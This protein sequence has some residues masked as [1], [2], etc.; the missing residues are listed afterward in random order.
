[1]PRVS[2]TGA[3][4]ISLTLC[5][6]S[7]LTAAAYAGTPF[8]PA[9]RG[10]GEP[11][12]SRGRPGRIEAP[13]PPTF[14]PAETPP[15]PPQASKQGVTAKLDVKLDRGTLHLHYTG[16][17]VQGMADALARTF[18]TN[19][20]QSHRVVLR[21]SSPGGSVDEGERVIDLLRRIRATH[22]LDTEVLHGDICASMCVPIYLQGE[23]RVAAR[24]TS[25]LFH[26]V[27]RT[28]NEGDSTRLQELAGASKR[29]HDLYYIPAGVNAA[30]LSEVQSRTDGHDFWQTGADLVARG[31]GIV[32]SLI[33]DLI[34]RL[35]AERD[36]AAAPSWR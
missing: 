17:V 6:S 30:F 8:D 24:V 28:L 12:P 34:P 26:R 18:E 21:I 22:K 2:K 19:R 25:W 7:L 20:G 33:E 10:P 31:T 13:L 23:R 32:T 5:A 9:P 16:P 35:G 1:M 3:F 36:P 4:A 27:T 15:R 11:A 14:R 29:L